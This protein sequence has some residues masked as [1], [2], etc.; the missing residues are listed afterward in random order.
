MGEMK[1]TTFKNYPNPIEWKAN[2][3]THTI[4]TEIL[5][6][7]GVVK[8]GTVIVPAT[9][10]IYKSGKVYEAVTAGTTVKMYKEHSF[11]VGDAFY[12]G[13]TGRTISAIDESNADYDS[14]TVSDVVTLTLD[15][16]V[17]NTNAGAQA[18]TGIVI[19]TDTTYF[20]SDDTVHLNVTDGAILN[21]DKLQNYSAIS[22]AGPMITTF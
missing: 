6:I 19:V 14:F 5:P 11:G 7:K 9:P 10:L 3:R 21:S 17:Y 12:D 1:K 20:E 8:A 4:T 15:E 22:P 13:A 16:V 2:V 18:T